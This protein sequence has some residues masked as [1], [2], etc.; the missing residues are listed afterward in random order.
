MGKYNYDFEC[1]GKLEIM[2]LSVISTVE[3]LSSDGILSFLDL[4][5][6]TNSEEL[7]IFGDLIDSKI[8]IC[9]LHFIQHDLFVNFFACSTV[10]AF[11]RSFFMS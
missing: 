11:C 5:A 10:A 9:V 7:K 8:G 1:D 4:N 3:G 2:S 6:F